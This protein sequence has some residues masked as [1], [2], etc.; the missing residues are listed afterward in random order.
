MNHVQGTSL[1]TEIH[2]R[3]GHAELGSDHGISYRNRSLGSGVDGKISGAA[4]RGAGFILHYLGDIGFTTNK[5][6]HL[7]NIMN[8]TVLRVAIGVRL[9]DAVYVTF[10][11]I[12]EERSVRTFTS[13]TIMIIFN[14]Y[15]HFTAHVRARGARTATSNKAIHDL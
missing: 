15:M 2:A 4:L 14:R 5:A 11:G 7:R 13:Q 12:G 10:T 3:A 9:T 1:F 6:R 8:F